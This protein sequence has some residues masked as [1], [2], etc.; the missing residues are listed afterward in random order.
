MLKS[1][2]TVA[3]AALLLAACDPPPP[4]AVAMAPASPQ[5][6]VGFFVTFNTGQATLSPEG[7]AT[8]QQASAAYRARSGARVAAVGHTDTTG[9]ADFNRAL[10]QRRAEAVRDA[11]R[12]EEHTSELQSQ[13]KLV[14]RL[15]LE[16]KKAK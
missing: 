1:I 10:S 13:S 8:V 5:P 16:K 6:L 7:M 14:C 12:S 15:L 4:Q 3:A 11:M 2:L 9:P